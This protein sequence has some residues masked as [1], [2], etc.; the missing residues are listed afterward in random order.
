MTLPRD[1]TRLSAVRDFQ[2]WRRSVERV[3]ARLD[4]RAANSHR[5]GVVVNYAGSTLPGDLL[6]ANGQVVSRA[7]YPRL[8]GEIG[9]TYNTGGEAGTAFRLPNYTTPPEHGS[10]AITT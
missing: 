10:W 7:D 1:P 2:T 5:A 6:A 8:F 9:T 4:N 3:L